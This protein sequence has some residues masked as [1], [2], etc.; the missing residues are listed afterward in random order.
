MV[1]VVQ[2]G[3]FRPDFAIIN[4]GKDTLRCLALALKRMPTSHQ[5]IS[6]HDEKDL[7]FIGLVGM[8]DP[9]R[10]E[11]R[12]SIL[13]RMTAGIRVMVVT[14]DNKATAESLCRKIDAFDHY[15]DFVD[16]SFTASEFEDLLA[17]EKTMAFQRMTLFT[18]Y[19]DCHGIRNNCSQGAKC[20][21][22]MVLVDDNFATIVIVVAEGRA[23]Y[24]NTKQ[25]IRYMISSNIR[26]VVCIFIAAILG[27]PDT[28]VPTYC[29]N[30]LVISHGLCV[31]ELTADECSREDHE[32]GDRD[33]L[34]GKAESE[35]EAEG[36]ED[37]KFIGADDTYSDHIFLSAKPLAKRVASPLHDDGKKDCN[38]FYGNESFYALF[39]LHQ[40]K[41]WLESEKDIRLRDWKAIEIEILNVFQLLTAK[42]VV[43]LAF[44]HTICDIT[45]VYPCMKFLV[46]IFVACYYRPPYH[47]FS[48]MDILPGKSTRPNGKL[49]HNSIINGPYVRRMIPEPGDPSREVP[50][51]E[52]FHVKTDDE[53]TEKELK[54]IEADDQAIQ[55]ILLGVPEDIYVAVDSCETA[56]EI[57][58]RVQQMMKGSDI[59]I[60]EKKA[61]LYNEWESEINT[62]QKRLPVISM[63]HQDQPSFNQNY[64]QQPMPNPEDITDP[65]TAMNMALAIMAKKFKLN[66]STPTNNNQRIS[67]NPRN[68]QIAQPGMN[69][70]QDRQMQIVGG[71]AN[72][73]LN[74]NGNLVTARAEGNATGHNGNQIRCYNCRGVGHF[75]RNC[76]VRPKRRDAAY[77]QTQLLIAQKEEAGI[78]LQA[79]EFDPMAAAADLDEI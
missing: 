58:L 68:R 76:T 63:L 62:F 54:Q 56:Y 39:W 60:Q 71:N 57:W 9:P 36:I 69:M 72:Q 16:C 28:L 15:E 7:T 41:A 77:L 42:L 18:R 26:E 29:V 73:N 70:G 14:G 4:G 23:I 31:S 5:N 21:S 22:N 59:G 48:L 61:K 64:M 44:H 65:T 52:I 37:A 67:S 12:N 19:R 43:Y 3:G 8:L 13:S 10:E 51:N 75:A 40:V 32:D 46:D 27:I 50:V 49:I 66:Y 2:N 17:S 35:G 38:V 1:F 55:T 33:D 47:D 30:S 45:H 34:D 6:L 11:V 24:N 78:Q 74:E 53:L 25:F 79:K 20:A